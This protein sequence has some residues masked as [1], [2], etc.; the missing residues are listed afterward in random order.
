[1]GGYDREWRNAFTRNN[2]LYL[3]T[4]PM[5]PDRVEHF[6][7]FHNL[8]LQKCYGRRVPFRVFRGELIVDFECFFGWKNPINV[9]KLNGY[10]RFHMRGEMC[11]SGYLKR[12]DFW[13]NRIAMQINCRHNEQPVRETMFAIDETVTDA[14]EQ[15]TKHVQYNLRDQKTTSGNGNS[16]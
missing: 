15:T 8:I 7:R 13:Q 9:F 11:D 4:G 10:D 3:I 16:A 14:P 6:K 12:M 2:V 5:P 1:M